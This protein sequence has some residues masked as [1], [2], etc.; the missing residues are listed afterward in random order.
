MSLLSALLGGKK[1]ASDKITVLDRNTYA[2]A[3]TK[4]DV[5]LVDV[6]TPK[7]YESGHI[8]NAKNIDFF[9]AVNFKKAFEKMNKE[10][11]IYVYCR[12]GAR[13]QKAAKKLVS[14]GFSKIYDLK[15][16]YSLWNF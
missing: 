8:K 9:D 6:R 11:P 12:S 13:S 10:L 2:K 1:E 3:I 4:K 15:H 7:E 5:Q 14:M 16:G